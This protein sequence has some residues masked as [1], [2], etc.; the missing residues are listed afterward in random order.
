MWPGSGSKIWSELWLSDVTRASIG[1]LNW[2]HQDPCRNIRLVTRDWEIEVYCRVGILSKGVA[3]SWS[4]HLIEPNSSL[5]TLILGLYE[6][7]NPDLY[8]LSEAQI[9]L[10]WFNCNL[11]FGIVTPFSLSRELDMREH[12]TFHPPRSI[13]RCWV[14][15]NNVVIFTLLQPNDNA[16]A[17]IITQICQKRPE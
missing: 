12:M 13:S 3:Q 11:M 16:N 4:S 10:D 2:S 17:T 9:P 8:C 5:I 6:Q 1:N 15:G 14:I 7:V